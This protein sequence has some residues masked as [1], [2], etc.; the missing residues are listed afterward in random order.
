MPTGVTLDR[1]LRDLRVETSPA[2]AA[3]R[4]ITGTGEV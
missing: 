4:T 1:L 2:D 3:Q